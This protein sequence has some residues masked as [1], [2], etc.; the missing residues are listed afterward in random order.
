MSSSS[1]LTPKARSFVVQY[2]IFRWENAVILAGTILL[3]GLA[4]HPFPW[5]PWWGWPALGL[6]GIILITISSLT[7]VKSNADFL[8]KLSQGQYDLRQIKQPE[9]RK[10]IDAALEYQ[11]R[12]EKKV[13][14][15]KRASL[16]WDRPEAIAGQIDNW[17]S[18]MYQLAL[19][20]DAYRQDTLT[21]TE[22]EQVPKD[23]ETLKRQRQ[24]E[25][26]PVFQT[27][28][29]QVIDSKK[30]Q[31]ETLQALQTRMKQAEFQMEQS[32]TALATMDSQMQLID[33]QEVGGSRSERM[34][35][36][37]NEQVN[38]LNDLV[39]SINEVYN[40]KKD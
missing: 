3:T 32:L 38:R 12:I 20:L 30:K 10:Y 7:N 39:S 27:E 37:I 26:N 34:H 8:L 23:L 25:S 13:R 5:W 35:E 2:A 31:W 4:N 28:M 1:D 19:R 11:R 29:D 9:L 36:D 6:V 14:S 21:A 22:I 33:A 16:L 15:P 40:Y 18:N 17:I 24:K